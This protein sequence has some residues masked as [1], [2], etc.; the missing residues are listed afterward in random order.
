MTEFAEEICSLYLRYVLKGSCIKS[1]YTFYVAHI[2]SPN[3]LMVIVK[4]FILVDDFNFYKKNPY[5]NDFPFL[6]LLFV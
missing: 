4:V 1:I 3:I 6:S 5:R 2:I